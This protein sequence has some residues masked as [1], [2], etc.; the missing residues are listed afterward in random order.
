MARGGLRMTD[1]DLAGLTVRNGAKLAAPAKPKTATQNMQALGRLP[2]GTMNKTETRFEQYLAMLTL[3][4]EVLWHRFEGIKLMLAPNTSITIDF[5]VMM[6]SGELHMIDVKGSIAM[7][8]EDFKAKAKI[9][10]ATYPFRFFTAIPRGRT[11][12]EWDITQIG[13]SQ[14]A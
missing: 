6:R 5:A 3:S 1:Q 9:A 13:A 11:G 14:E 7:I 2:K 8:S 10:A 12:H 4:G